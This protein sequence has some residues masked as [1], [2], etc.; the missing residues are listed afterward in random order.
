LSKLV[1]DPSL[2]TR[3]C[4]ASALCA[5]AIHD[6]PRALVLFAKLVDADDLLLG[7]D[8]VFRFV[9]AGLCNHAK[10]F[11]PF[12]SRMLASKY[13]E[14]RRLGGTLACLARLY[15]A[16]MHDLAETALA[17]DTACRM[18]AVKVAK[19]NFMHPDCNEWCEPRLKLLFD[20]TSDQVRKEAA[21]CFWHLW[22]R[23]TLPLAQF[24]SLIQAFLDSSAF[25]D[26]PTYLLHALED[27][28]ERVPEAI[29]NVC[30]VFVAECAEQ[31]RDIRTSLAGDEMTVGKLV[32]R[33]YAQLESKGLRTRTLNL[34]DRMCE[35]GLQ[36]AG[37]HFVD[38]ER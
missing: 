8:P 21:G 24:N 3:A 12:I 20:D 22:Q 9:R 35:E 2:A 19:D 10:E 31:A 30:E 16:S 32:F 15:D 13:E 1:E 4:V 29:L 26:E 33:A 34:I 11:R 7:T 23:P 6:F 17:G 36:S 18:G 27:T 5:V 14:V 38:F 37:K 28:R 25:A